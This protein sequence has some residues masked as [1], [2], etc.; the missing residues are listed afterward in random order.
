MKVANFIVPV[1]AACGHAYFLYHK[2]Q[3]VSV[4]SDV[5]DISLVWEVCPAIVGYLLMIFLGRYI[6]ANRK[7]FEAKEAMI[8]YNI[9][10]T[11]LSAF[12]GIGFFMGTIASGWNIFTMPVQQGPAGRF[13]GFLM[14]MNYNSKFV[15]F[16]D[17][18]WMVIR[19]KDKQISFLHVWHHMVMAPVMWEGVHY[20][21]GGTSA[22]G[23]MINSFIHTVMYSYYLLAGLGVR[24][25][26][27]LKQ[28]ITSM[29]LTQFVLIAAHSLFHATHPTYWPSLLTW[30]QM[31]LMVNMLF[32]FS[33]FFA[34]AYCKKRTTADAAAIKKE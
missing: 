13:I 22:F 18:F 30:T 3:S 28:T 8:V 9:Y 15:E 34:A 21:P 7:P 16:F 23:P 19:K 2:Y 1:A 20:F 10:I 29:Q 11:L 12:M 24:V 4:A 17:T 6:M 26:R 25:P 32:M 5:S 31:V 33:S 14:W 27:A